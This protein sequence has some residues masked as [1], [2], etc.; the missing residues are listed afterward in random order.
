[1]ER[2]QNSPVMHPDVPDEW[3]PALFVQGVRVDFPAPTKKV[4]APK[5]RGKKAA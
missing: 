5:V 2:Y 4:K 1:M 3:K